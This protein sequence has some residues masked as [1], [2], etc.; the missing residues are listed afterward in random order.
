MPGLESLSWI[1]KGYAGTKATIL[2]MKSLVDEGK[3]TKVI[4]D[5]AQR[6]VYQARER[7]QRAEVNAI[8]NWVKSNVRFVNDPY[9]V[10]TLRQPW[11]LVQMPQP[12]GDC[13]DLSVLINTLCAAIGYNTA[14]K[15]IKADPR[16][17]NQFSHV[18]A[19]VEINGKWIAADGSQ[20]QVSLG[21]EP[22]SHN[23]YE[24]WGYST[25]RLTQRSAP[26]SLKG[27]EMANDVKQR[28]IDAIAGIGRRPAVAAVQSSRSNV[29]PGGNY[30]SAA[31]RADRIVSAESGGHSYYNDDD[32]SGGGGGAYGV[33]PIENVT[34]RG[35]PINTVTRLAHIPGPDYFAH[36]RRNLNE[37]FHDKTRYV[38][39]LPD[40]TAVKD[41]T[42]TAE[43]E[44]A[45]TGIPD[46]PIVGEEF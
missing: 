46:H 33:E 4:I 32:A 12:S 10:E 43:E 18:Y 30:A 3:R 45:H 7:D 17:P 16:M 37:K 29:Q 9:G 44:R 31:F 5:L 19:L 34:S 35:Y 23:G 26:P 1:P 13:D 8:F 14:F 38:D 21:W 42:I 24:V 15:T 2:K 40:Q 20:K 41:G 6:I 28:I 11:K 27:L 22:P 36:E 25:G 39:Y